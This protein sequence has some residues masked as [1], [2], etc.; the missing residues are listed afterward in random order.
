[1]E[2]EQIAITI[3][4]ASRAADPSW[5]TEPEIDIE[6]QTYLTERHAL[7]ADLE[8]GIYP[9][10]DIPLSRADVEWLLI[11]QEDHSD[12]LDGQDGH[13]RRCIGVD[14]RGADL[15]Q[16]NLSNL[17]LARLLAGR[18]WV[19]QF[20]AIEEQCDMARVRLE[21]AD[22]GGAHLEGAFLGGAHLE[23]AFL[24]GAHLE[25]AYLEWAHIDGARLEGAHLG[26]ANLV[27]AHLEGCNLAGAHLVG[28]NLVGA[29]LEGCNLAGAH[30]AGAILVGASLKGMPVPSD[31]LKR[32]RQW[33]KDVLPPAD[34]RGAFFDSTTML[35]DVV[36]GE[37]KFGFITLA[38]LHWGG[39]NL[40]V[41]DWEAVTI[42]GDERRARQ[43]GWLYNYQGAVRAYRQLATVLREQGLNEEALQFAY[44]AQLL[45][46]GVLWR[47]MLQLRRHGRKGLGRLAKKMVSYFFSWL[48]D[49]FAGYGYK[50]LRSLITYLIVIGL[51]M[52]IYFALGTGYGTHLSWWQSLAM[53][54]TAFHGRLFLSDGLKSGG[55]Q[56]FVTAIEAFVG[57]IIEVSL[58]AIYVQRLFRK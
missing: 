51:F 45:Q 30:L 52:L 19:V 46:R 35:E 43:T 21:G 22:L 2:L 39:V 48:L 28:A 6:R 11:T 1:M 20:P 26:E 10:Q 27:G 44:R 5:R 31:F 29:H 13:R 54:L 36:L 56:V 55:Q 25:G 4:H 12:P 58:I 18:S 9:F 24:G 50:P 53:S 42:L 15:R 41:V 16:I 34:L 32:V 47:Q 49:L 57:L 17:P 33:D 3:P 38:N 7:V 8:R 37:E 23:G 14:L 40:S